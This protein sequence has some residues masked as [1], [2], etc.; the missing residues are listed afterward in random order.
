V[1]SYDL[2]RTGAGTWTATHQASGI[3]VTV[4]ADP[5]D[6][7]VRFDGL[8]IWFDTAPTIGAPITVDLRATG[9]LEDPELRV[10]RATIPS[11]TAAEE[12]GYYDEGLLRDLATYLPEVAVLFPA[13]LSAG[14]TALAPEAKNAVRANY[15]LYLL[16]KEHT[17]RFLLETNNL[18]IDLEVGQTPGLE[19]F[20]RLHRVVDVLKELEEASRRA[21]ENERRSRRVVQGDFADADIEQVTVVGGAAELRT[22]VGPVVGSPAAAPAPGG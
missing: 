15:H 6:L 14:W 16:L 12:A 8:F 18:M 19:E 4:S 10:L 22:I 11:P 17:R 9:E 5:G 7:V 20:K 21:I 1:A 13:D 2:R 3:V